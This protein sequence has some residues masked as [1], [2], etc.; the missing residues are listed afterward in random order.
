MTDHINPDI[1]A[2]VASAAAEL[3]KA[4]QRLVDAV[5]EARASGYSWAK[6]GKLFGVSRQA[7]WE[8]FHDKVAA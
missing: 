6:I 2:A 1:Y 5:R 3:E 8:R 7:A 4:Q